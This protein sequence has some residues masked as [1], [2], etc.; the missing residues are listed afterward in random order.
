VNGNLGLIAI[1]GARVGPD[2]K[3][4]FRSAET[5]VGV[6]LFEQEL[7]IVPDHRPMIP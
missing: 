7:S 6:Q 5:L 4:A 1:K 2:A 3:G